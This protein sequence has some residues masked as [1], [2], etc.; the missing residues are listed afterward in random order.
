MD[1][2]DAMTNNRSYREALTHEHAM[3]ELEANSG[4]QFDPE[5]VEALKAALLEK[6]ETANGSS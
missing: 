5:V 1:T 4:G 6:Q 2:Y 3:A